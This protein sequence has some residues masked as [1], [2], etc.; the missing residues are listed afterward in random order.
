[1]R[2]TPV[3]DGHVQGNGADRVMLGQSIESVIAAFV[4]ERSRTEEVLHVLTGRLLH[5][6]EDE[7]RSVARELHDGLNQALA[8]LRVEVGI[9]LSR[10]PSSARFVRRQLSKIRDRVQ[11]L[12]EEVRR[13]SHRLHPAVLEH[14]GLIS[15]L[16]SC[17]S[18]F[19][20]YQ[21]IHALFV[22]EGPD[23]P[24]PFEVA[25]CLYRIVQEALRNVAKHAKASTVL[26]SLHSSNKEM[27][28]CI[29]DD[30]QGFDVPEAKKV[31][32][33]GLV[34]MEERARIVGGNFSIDSQPGNG[35]RIEI[36]VPPGRNRDEN[37]Y[38][39]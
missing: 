25:V 4:A 38:Q 37:T 27:K 11:E 16:R 2:S 23:E 20:E 5:A 39:R 14:L 35:T 28:L 26:V 8:M 29:S 1:V 19:S 36:I 22:H 13:I 12:S 18:E 9:V 32:G 24:V 17:C 3:L 10:V 7:R 30:G 34:S 33:L 21:H 31:S 15:A 6:Q